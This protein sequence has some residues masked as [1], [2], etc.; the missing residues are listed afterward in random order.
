M[1]PH[2]VIF[3]YIEKP[4]LVSSGSIVNS[5]LLYFLYR[6]PQ[7]CFFVVEMESIEKGIK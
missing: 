6:R 2:K 1:V 4:F 5:V 7:G 3:K